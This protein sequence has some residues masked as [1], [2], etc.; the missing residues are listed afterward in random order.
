ME[1][2]LS[3]GLTGPA[4]DLGDSGPDLQRRFEFVLSHVL[5]AQSR[6]RWS[7]ST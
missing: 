6:A 7:F 3:A 4:R 5:P 1:A 2:A